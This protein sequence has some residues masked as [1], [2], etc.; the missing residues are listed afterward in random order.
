MARCVDLVHYNICIP[1]AHSLIC[2]RIY[3]D[4]IISLTNE[5]FFYQNCQFVLEPTVIYIFITVLK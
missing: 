1:E 4:E 2:Q 5:E 3:A